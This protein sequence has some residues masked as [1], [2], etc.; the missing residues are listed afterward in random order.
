MNEAHGNSIRLILK[1]DLYFNDI[2]ISYRVH[3]P[4]LLLLEVNYTLQ[5]L[6]SQRLYIA[7]LNNG[8]YIQQ[9]IMKMLNG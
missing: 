7:L 6:F 1:N 5:L 3:I 2:M 9:A 8:R 4:V